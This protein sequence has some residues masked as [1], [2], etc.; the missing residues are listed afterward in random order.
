MTE[1]VAGVAP[2][3]GDAPRSEPA[4]TAAH[5]AVVD[6]LLGWGAPRPR[7]ADDFADRLRARLEEGLATVAGGLDDRLWL[8]K[9]ALQALA[10]DGRW[11]DRRD[12]T[13]TPSVALVAGRITH[14]AA[15]LDAATGRSRDVDE[16]LD[17]AVREIAS[18][19]T[20]SEADL[21]NGLDALEAADLRATCRDRLVEWRLLWPDLDRVEV[22]FEHGLRAQFADGRV[23]LSGRPDLVVRSPRPRPGRATDLVV[24]LKS[25]QRNEVR[26]RA[27]LRLYGVLWTLKYRRPPFRWASFYL[28]E[29]RWDAE[30]F[31]EPLLLGAADRVV[32]AAR[33]A[34]RL[35]SPV[36]EDEL[37]L[38]PGAHC[39]FCGRRETCPV[40]PATW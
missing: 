8:S 34:A 19:P 9:S 5:R 16:L 28:A 13:F 31:S 25:G 20:S 37:Q 39:R 4:T 23:V 27:D 32:D 35:T 3:G 12:G 1:P 18:D 11:L 21:L 22:S 10:C 26:D 15:E 38:V 40:G 17:R 36:P 30:D 14:R 2:A 29:G 6:D 33:R 24:D 7:V